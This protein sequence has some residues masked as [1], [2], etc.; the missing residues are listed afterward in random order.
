MAPTPI[1]MALSA[2]FSGSFFREGGT[3]RPKYSVGLSILATILNFLSKSVL[4]KRIWAPVSILLLI[5][6]FIVAVG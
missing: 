4:E 1:L 5:S 2:D 6:S 3:L